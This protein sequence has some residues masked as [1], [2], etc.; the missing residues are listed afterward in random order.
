MARFELVLPRFLLSHFNV[1]GADTKETVK[2]GGPGSSRFWRLAEDNGVAPSIPLCFQY[3]A[4]GDH[5]YFKRRTWIARPLAGEG[6]A[7][8]IMESPFYGSRCPAEQIDSSLC[9]VRSSCL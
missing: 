5:G 7:S 9:N 8:L 6:V 4:T 1:E 2:Q 3:S